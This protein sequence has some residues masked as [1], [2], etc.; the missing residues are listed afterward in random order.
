MSKLTIPIMADL[1]GEGKNPEILFWVGCAGSFDARAQKITVAFCKILNSANVDFAILGKEESCTGDPA[2]R[3]GNEFVFQM[4]ALQ[5]IETLN[6]YQVKK[7]VTT[8]PH[9][10]NI[11]KNEYPA[12]GGEYEVLH[13]TQFLQNLIDEGRL[14][15]EEGGAFDGQKITYHDSCYLGRANGVYKAPRSL[16]ENL[17]NQLVEMDRSKSLGLCCGAGGAQMFKE[18]EPGNK[19]INIERTEE[20]LATGANIVAV[21]CPFCTTMMQDGIKAKEQQDSVMVYDLAELIVNN[22]RL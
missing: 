8:C 22:N 7:I 1:A 19:R 3:A 18:D 2:R 4:T 15:L 5:N 21:N 6:M 12:L 9:C 20:A 16:L 10:F 11:I 14:Q 17:D 13:H